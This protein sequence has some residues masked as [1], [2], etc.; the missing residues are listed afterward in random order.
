[1]SIGDNDQQV[2]F[3]EEY[4]AK[5]NQTLTELWIEGQSVKAI[6]RAKELSGIREKFAAWLTRDVEEQLYPIE[7]ALRTIG[8]GSHV[9]PMVAPGSHRS[10]IVEDVY[11]A[12]REVTEIGEDKKGATASV[13]TIT[14]RLRELL[15]T[16]DLVDLRIGIVKLASSR[17][18]H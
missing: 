15:G 12:L 9:L 3:N 2:Q 7:S 16:K 18:R 13:A 14:D 10:K 6:E 11:N 8:A 4:L 17:V 1:M 5:V